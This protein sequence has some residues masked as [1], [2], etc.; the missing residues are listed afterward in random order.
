MLFASVLIRICWIA[1]DIFICYANVPCRHTSVGATLNQFQMRAHRPLKRKIFRLR[2]TLGEAA[3]Y[4]ENFLKG[5]KG[6]P[7]FS[8]LP[9]PQGLYGDS[10]PQGPPGND[11]PRGDRGFKG[12]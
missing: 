9:G 1:H 11:G 2:G 4:P 3:Q 10:G 5:Q 7:G 6:E 8:G 12:I